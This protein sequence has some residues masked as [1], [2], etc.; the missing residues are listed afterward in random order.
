MLPLSTLLF[1]SLASSASS[2]TSFP[3]LFFPASGSTAVRARDKTTVQPTTVRQ[4]SRIP[5]PDTSVGF[6]LW[7]RP[8]SLSPS[9][10]PSIFRLF[11]R[12]P[13]SPS[14][15]EYRPTPASIVDDW[16]YAIST[17]RKLTKGRPRF[18]EE[19]SRIDRK[20]AN[21]TNFPLLPSKNSFSVSSSFMI[22]LWY[23]CRKWNF[24]FSFTRREER[25]IIWKRYLSVSD[26]LV[27]QIHKTIRKLRA[28]LRD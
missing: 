28:C 21:E 18:L 13:A 9:I 6:R 23:S 16:K 26:D 24:F 10:Y 2:S 27:L 7:R 12:S 25:A 8:L 17:S 5:R 4:F 3:P 19:W 15:R 14:P 20:N 22:Y 1:L 11:Y